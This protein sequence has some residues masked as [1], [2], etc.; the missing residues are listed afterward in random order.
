MSETVESDLMIEEHIGVQNQPNFKPFCHPYF[1]MMRNFLAPRTANYSPK[2]M[3]PK[4]F[5][6]GKVPRHIASPRTAALPS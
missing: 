1:V 2:A 6:P 5:P 3:P 4:T